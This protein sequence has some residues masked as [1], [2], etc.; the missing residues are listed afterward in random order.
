MFWNKKSTANVKLSSYNDFLSAGYV[1]MKDAKSEDDLRKH[2]KAVRSIIDSATYDA[3]QLP[4]IEKRIA[5]TKLLYSLDGIVEVNRQMSNWLDNFLEGV[6]F[7]ED[8]SLKIDF[9]G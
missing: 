7:F 6:Q 8:S 9:G 3:I 5:M 4:S 1:A 2:L